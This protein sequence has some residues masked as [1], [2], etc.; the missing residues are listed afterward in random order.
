MAE[1]KM[2]MPHPGNALKILGVLAIVYGVIRAL[3]LIKIIDVNEKAN[4]CNVEISIDPVCPI[5]DEAAKEWLRF[6]IMAMCFGGGYLMPELENITDDITDLSY[7]RK[8]L[9][10]KEVNGW[11]YHTIYLHLKSIY[12]KYKPTTF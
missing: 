10:K 12:Y 7:L 11:E 8:M 2:M 3:I 9:G 6:K 1:E 5:I 4:W